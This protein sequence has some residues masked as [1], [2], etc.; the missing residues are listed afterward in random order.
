VFGERMPYSLEE[1]LLRM[2]TW[3][4]QHGARASKPFEG[5]EVTMNFPQA[6]L[7]ETAIHS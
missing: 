4:K 1:G 7:I 3:V 6:W 5:I 2:A